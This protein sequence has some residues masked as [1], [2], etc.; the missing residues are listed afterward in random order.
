MVTV[1]NHLTGRGAGRTVNFS[2]RV[3]RLRL[4]Y[5]SA[6]RLFCA[7]KLLINRAIGHERVLSK[8]PTFYIIR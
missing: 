4:L 1:T 6:R 3:P 2:V 7:S 8:I 5:P